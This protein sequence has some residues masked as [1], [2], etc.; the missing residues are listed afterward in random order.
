[1]I[2]NHLLKVLSGAGLLSVALLFSSC[3]TEDPG[4][5]QYEE[6]SFDVVDF[7]RL[8]MGDAF[9]IEVEQ[10]SS[11]SIRAEGDY[12]NVQDLEVFKSGTTLIIRYD[13]NSNRR[14]E[15]TIIITMPELK[16]VNFSGASFSTISGFESDG[17]LDFIL[18]GASIS[19]LDAGYGQINLTVS[20]ASDLV[21][22][23]LGDEMQ[24][25][26]SGA[27]SVSAFDY[28]VREAHLNVTGASHGKVTVSDE[29][30]AIA[31]GASSV[32]YRG[33]PA[34]T[35]SVSGA[36]TVQAD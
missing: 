15:T 34:V 14:H 8:E 3:E 17:D 23:G 26:I 30:K 11:F 25:D 18:S 28:P 36:S 32:F 9:H 6:K 16:G 12:R 33:T 1:M 13:E 7:D 19:Q 2:M 10:A 31:S 27:S 35:S 29:L 20:G 24:A 21:L 4:P 22:R 5:L